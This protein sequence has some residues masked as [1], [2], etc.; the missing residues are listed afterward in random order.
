VESPGVTVPGFSLRLARAVAQAGDAVGWG[1]E[2]CGKEQS[3]CGLV[4][5]RLSPIA[6]GERQSD[7]SD[8]RLP[9]GWSRKRSA[10]AFTLA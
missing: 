1:Q 2:R 9:H 4:R 10:T 6:Q 5:C 8:V 3:V 7:V